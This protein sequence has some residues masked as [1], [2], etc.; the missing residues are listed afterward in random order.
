MNK[1]D[2]SSIIR[3]PYLTNLLNL[4]NKDSANKASQLLVSYEWLVLHFCTAF[5]FF[6]IK[7]FSFAEKLVALNLTFV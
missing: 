3:G 5:L 4:F 1:K 7:I 2:R 6:L